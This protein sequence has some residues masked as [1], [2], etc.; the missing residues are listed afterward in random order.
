MMSMGMS[1][2]M[3]RMQT[4]M[5]RTKHRKLMMDQRTIWKTEGILGDVDGYEREGGDDVDADEEQ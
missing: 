4:R 3:A 5:R 2:R 1:A